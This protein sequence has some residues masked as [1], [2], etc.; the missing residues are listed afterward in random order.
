MLSY[1]IYVNFYID[2]ENKNPYPFCIIYAK[3]CLY[4]VDY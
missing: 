4:Y 2:N 1:V 3:R